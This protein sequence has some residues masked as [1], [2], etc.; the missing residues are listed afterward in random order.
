MYLP[1][2]NLTFRSKWGEDI[3]ICKYMHDGCET[4]PLLVHTLVHEVCDGLM[5]SDEIDQLIELMAAL[6]VIAGGRYLYYAGRTNKFYN[7]CYLL[8]AEED[9]REDW[10]ALHQRAEVALM[11]GGG[12]G[13]DYSR[14]RAKHSLC[15]STG[16]VASGPLPAMY[17]TN[18]I[19]RNVMQGGGRRSAIYASLDRTHSDVW[20]FLNAK[21]WKDMSVGSTGYSYWD[22]KCQDADFPC[23]LD[24]TNISVNYKT[25]WLNI[26]IGADAYGTEYDNTIIGD[27]TD[28]VYLKNVFQALSTG[29][30][31]FSFNFFDKEDETLRNACTEVTSSDDSDVCNLASLNMG[32]I[33]SLEEM[34][35]ATYLA[36]KFLLC[37]TLRAKLPYQKVYDVR[38]RNR[39]LGLGLMGVHEW[40]LKRGYRYEFNPELQRWMEVYRNVSDTTSAR[41]AD[42]IDVSR[43]VGNRAI[44]PTGTIGILAGTTT[45]IEPLYAVA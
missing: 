9:T 27:D 3:F 4:M 1:N 33:E 20:E 37:G 30:P 2:N 6:K 35:T 11:T 24:M 32:R 41:F 29:D 14:Y 5:P 45:G 34:E 16:G 31:G 18:E 38:E 26:P 22:V 7:N 19:G 28:E 44:A 8:R 36:T 17:S 21:N 15:R 40:L 12:I 39:R 23:P 25:D 42:Q 43:P 10:G 13:V